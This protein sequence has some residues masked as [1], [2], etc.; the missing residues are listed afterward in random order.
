[1]SDFNPVLT[2]PKESPW[3]W[4]WVLVAL[5]FAIGL[6]WGAFA[7]LGRYEWISPAEEW[8]ET[9]RVAVDRVIVE[10]QK[11]LELLPQER[12]QLKDIPEAKLPEDIEEILPELKN[13]DIDISPNT[14]APAFDLKPAKALLGNTALDI[15]PSVPLDVKALE[16]KEIKGELPDLTSLKL[17]SRPDQVIIP[18]GNRGLDTLDPDE[19]LKNLLEA[20]KKQGVEIGDVDGFSTFNELLNLPQTELGSRKAIIGSDLLFESNRYELQDTAKTSLYKVAMLIDQNPT[21]YC[22]VEGHT[23]SVGSDEDNIKLSILRA[24]SVKDW[25]VNTL[26]LDPARIIVIGK[27]ESEPIVKGRGE[28]SEAL[29]RRVEIKMRS[30]KP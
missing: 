12:E 21:M 10:E 7:W 8:V 25:L 4:L 3:H 18:E 16:I 28:V 9:D 17:K 14:E 23:D 15:Q 1:M 5:V 26:Y 24:Q 29:N 6:H 19:L 11:D 13:V 22:W 27:G 2:Q 30:T 20:N